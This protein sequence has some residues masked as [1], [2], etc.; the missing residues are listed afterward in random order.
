MVSPEFTPDTAV[1]MILQILPDC[2]AIYRF[3][4]WGSYAERHDSDLDIA[5]MPAQR[6]QQVKRWELA[7]TLAS[8]ARRDIDLVDLVSASTVLRMQIV[9]HGERLYQ[10]DAHEV[11]KFEDMVFSSYA[12][13]NEERHEIVADVM[14]RGSVYGQ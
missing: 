11:E 14:Q 9:A 12:R 4:S 2:L 6:L 7:Q 10:N 1:R 8:Y 5:I 13:L 3:G